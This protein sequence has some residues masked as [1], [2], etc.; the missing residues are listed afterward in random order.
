MVLQRDCFNKLESRIRYS[1]CLGVNISFKHGGLRPCKDLNTVSA[2]RR[3]H[4]M[5]KVVVPALPSNSV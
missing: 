2:I 5:S 3:S 4:C 1:T